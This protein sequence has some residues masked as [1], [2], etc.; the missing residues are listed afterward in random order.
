MGEMSFPSMAL[1]LAWKTGIPLMAPGL[2]P[3]TLY[4]NVIELEK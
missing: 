1:R 3:K 4:F 2:R